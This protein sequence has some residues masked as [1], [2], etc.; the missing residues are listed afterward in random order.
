MNYLDLAKQSAESVATSFADGFHAQ[1]EVQASEAEGLSRTLAVQ[2][3]LL[4]SRN[5]ISLGSSSAY[6]DNVMQAM[7]EAVFNFE[8]N[9]TYYI[10]DKYG[11]DEIYIKNNKYGI[12][13]VLSVSFFLF[14][15]N[16]LYKMYA[17]NMKHPA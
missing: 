3:I 10:Y 15:L 16:I 11:A 12:Y 7:N 17:N 6:Y 1:L 4:E 14:S 13:D 5:G 9:I 8:G 2:S